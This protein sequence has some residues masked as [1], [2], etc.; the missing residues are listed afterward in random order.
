M[1]KKF[2]RLF[3]AIMILIVGLSLT[4]FLLF[5]ISKLRNF[6]FFGGLTARV[7]TDQKVVALTF[8]DAPTP[9]SDEVVQI[10][11]EKQVPATFYMIGQNME[12]YPV[13]TQNIVQAGIELGN[14]SYSHQRFVLKSQSFIDH[15]IQTTNELIRNSGY[16]GEITFRPPTGKKLFGLPWYLKQHNIKTIMWD[17]EPDTFVRDLSEGEEKTNFLVQYTLEHVQP[18]SIILLH[19]FCESC[20][21]DRAAIGRIVDQLREQGYQ[22][23]TVSELL[24]Y[25]KE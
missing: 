3:F 4:A 21:S 24:K 14:H 1:K 25:V 12:K 17:V 2:L 20:A 15:E 5:R 22:F 9:K 7:E 6:Q 16:Q 13:E 10:L 19:P 23:V 11:Q 8:D 18:G